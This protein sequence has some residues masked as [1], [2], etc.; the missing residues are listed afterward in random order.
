ML[1]LLFAIR[2][3]HQVVTWKTKQ[4]LKVVDPKCHMELMNSYVPL[5]SKEHLGPL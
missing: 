2:M 5:L 4:K 3:V 1:S